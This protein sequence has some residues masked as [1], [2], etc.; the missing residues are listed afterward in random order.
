[1]ISIQDFYHI[2]RSILIVQVG[3][4]DGWGTDQVC[5]A[6]GLP[7][8][9]IGTVHE[10]CPVQC[11]ISVLLVCCV[12]SV[13]APAHYYVLPYCAHRWTCYSPSIPSSSSGTLLYRSYNNCYK[14]TVHA[15]TRNTAVNA[16]IKGKDVHLCGLLAFAILFEFRASV[17]PGGC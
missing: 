11:W 4:Q 10:H 2:L 5:S 13:V 6:L 8:R 16:W 14:T 17:V 9:I 1:M 7:N 3:F 15:A 12:V